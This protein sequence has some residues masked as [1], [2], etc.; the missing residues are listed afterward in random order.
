M[1]T[2]TDE[3]KTLAGELKAASDHVKSVAETTTAELKS[4]G[5][6]TDE[7]KLKADE[8]LAKLGD[9]TARLDAAEQKMVR[10]GSEETGRAKSAGEIVTADADMIAFMKSKPR[11]SVRVGMKDITSLTTDAMGS[12]G[13]LV[14]RDRL[15]LVAPME[16]RM[17]VRDLITP[18][19]TASNAIEYPKETGFTNSAAVVAEGA[20]KPQSDIKFD[21]VTQSVATIAHWVRASKQILD[22]APMLQSYIDGRLRYGLKY[23]E[24]L[25]LLMG[26]GTSGNLLGIYPQAVAYSAPITIAGATR[27]DQ[28]RL[29]MLQATLAELPATGIVLHPSDWAA[30]TLSKTTSNEYLFA[31]PQGITTPTIWGLPVVD[32]QAMTL[33]QFLIGAFRMG[34]QVFDREDANV[35][36]STEDR[37][38]FIRNLCTIR[39]EERLALAV[40]R[41]EAF[42]KGSLIALPA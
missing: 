10:R 6:Q 23:V 41:P 4:L 8:A 15:G 18:G 9:I 1:A 33:G 34:A 5:K 38:N 24:E 27:I 11:G 32:T 13:D 16:R 37:D 12:A 17:T 21:L 42:T 39:G 35:E 22:D 19:R 40:Y 20:L 31:N 29:A 3:L 14:P 30:I 26:D 36:V 28:I 7:T 25:Q 2:E